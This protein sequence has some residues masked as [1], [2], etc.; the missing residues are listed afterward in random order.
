MLFGELKIVVSCIDDPYN[1]SANSVYL[2]WDIHRSCRPSTQATDKQGRSGVDGGVG[3]SF[4]TRQRQS[5]SPPEFCLN[6][7]RQPI[8]NGSSR[9]TKHHQQGRNCSSICHHP[10]NL[11]SWLDKDGLKSSYLLFCFPPSCTVIAATTSSLCHH[12]F[13]IGAIT[14]GS[15]TSN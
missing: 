2:L 14:K 4:L 5:L 15:S 11:V 9:L 6:L 12:S 7:Q 8:I 1:N 13:L 10:T 3:A